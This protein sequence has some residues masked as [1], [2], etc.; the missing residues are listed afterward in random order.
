MEGNALSLAS[1]E[2]RKCYYCGGTK[3]V[4]YPTKEGVISRC[5]SGACPARRGPDGR[6]P[7]DRAP[8]F[9]VQLQPSAYMP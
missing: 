1:G 3:A 8:V 2:P 7:E 4:N 5:T 9:T 6:L